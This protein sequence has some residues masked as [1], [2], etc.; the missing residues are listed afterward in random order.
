MEGLVQELTTPSVWNCKL[1]QFS[2]SPS[3]L[4]S[5]FSHEA[6][7]LSSLLLDALTVCVGVLGNQFDCLMQQTAYPFLQK[8]GE[9]SLYVSN[10]AASTLKAVCKH[11][12]YRSAPNCA[13][14]DAHCAALPDTV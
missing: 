6:A 2:S 1:D 10:R 4:P 11:C 13:H 8:L 7:L 3:S 14:T 12:G 5:A 9:P